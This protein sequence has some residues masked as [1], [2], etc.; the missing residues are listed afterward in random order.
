MILL[1][2]FHQPLFTK[3]IEFDGFVH[4]TIGLRTDDLVPDL[5]NEA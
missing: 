2:S 5:L 3:S 4:Q 1:W